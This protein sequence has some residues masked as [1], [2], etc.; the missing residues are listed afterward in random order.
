[1]Y[2][3]GDLVEIDKEK[4]TKI[5]MS[6][7]DNKTPWLINKVGIITGWDPVWSKWKVLFVGEHHYELLYPEQIKL[8]E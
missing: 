1:M 8:A 5:Y 3:V 6:E 2:N 7:K 4:E